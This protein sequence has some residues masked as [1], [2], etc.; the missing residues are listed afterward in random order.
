MKRFASFNELKSIKSSLNEASLLKSAASEYGKNVFLSHSHHDNDILAGVIEIL[1]EHSGRV[2]VD[3]RDKGLPDEVS[4]ETAQRLKLAVH[5]CKRFVLLVTPRSRDSRW[6]PWELGLSDGVHQ[7]E[8]VALFPSSDHEYDTEWAER[9][10]LSL[11][12]R[13]IWGNFEGHD[14][15]WLL[16]DHRKNEAIRLR[17]WLT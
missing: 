2:Y 5:A 4:D 6:I 15:E 3:L 16:Y 12:R 17:N 11:Y 13:I 9:E 14:P 1:E 10:Y 7:A 8:S